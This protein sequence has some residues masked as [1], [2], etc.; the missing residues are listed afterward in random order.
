MEKLREYHFWVLEIR[1]FM[2]DEGTN[3]LV[4]WMEVSLCMVR[5]FGPP[6]ARPSMSNENGP[7]LMIQ[8]IMCHSGLALW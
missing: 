3:D 8:E 1:Y 5:A 2:I 4:V 7:G 6:T